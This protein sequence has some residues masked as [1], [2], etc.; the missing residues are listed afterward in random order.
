MFSAI[1]TQR[2]LTSIYGITFTTA[3]TRI[4][5]QYELILHVGTSIPE[6]L[7]CLFGILYIKENDA[8]L[9]FLIKILYFS[10]S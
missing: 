2:L 9:F 7:Y 5:T 10:W 1:V 3:N 6:M 4:M 8:S